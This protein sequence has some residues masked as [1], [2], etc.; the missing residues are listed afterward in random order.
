MKAL[1]HPNIIRVYEMFEDASNVYIVTEYLFT[2][3]ACATEDSSSTESI[4]MGISQ[5][6]MQGTF[7][8]R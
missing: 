1:D 2:N 7:L 6:L 4:Q 8:N 5:K 3:S